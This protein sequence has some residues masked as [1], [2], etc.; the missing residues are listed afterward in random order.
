MFKKAK[1]LKDPS[2]SEHAYE[3][4][5][6]LL[7]LSMRTVA[8]VE[9]KM[10]TRGYL[11]KVIDEVITRLLE[12]KYLNDEHYAE[13]YIE[14]LKRYKYYGRFMMRKKLWEKKL[15]RELAEQKLAELVSEDDEKEI[16]TNFV[17]KKFGLLSEIRMKEYEDKQ[18]I[19]RALLSRGFTIDVVKE[20]LAS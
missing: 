13:V 11:P 16:A 15:S 14:N 4:A 19:M 3:Y 10:K 2:N 7:N 8:E 20:L 18:K 1:P 5:I 9:E 17:E 12:D 6:F